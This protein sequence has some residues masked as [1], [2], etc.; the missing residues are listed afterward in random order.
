MVLN[1]RTSPSGHNNRFQNIESITI[2]AVKKINPA[3]T[4]ALNNLKL[5]LL[6]FKL[7]EKY[8]HLLG[9]TYAPE[10]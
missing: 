2:V 7:L 5:I 3:G 9:Y 10:Y 1:H 6:I 4:A 8:Q